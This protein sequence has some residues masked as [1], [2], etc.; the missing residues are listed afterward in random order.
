MAPLRKLILASQSPRR[1]ELLEA[2]HIPFEV[3]PSDAEEYHPDGHE[4][5]VIVIENTV[6]KVNAVLN[7][8][9]GSLIIGA[10]TIVWL[11]NETLAKPVD[12]NQAQQF[13]HRLSGATHTVYT[14]IVVAD[15]DSRQ[16]ESCVC[17]TDV[18]FKQ[19][20]SSDMD[21]YLR[22]INPYDKAGG[23]AIQGFGALVVEKINGC[24][25]NVMGLPVSMLD[26]LMHRF[27]VSL[28]DYI[29]TEG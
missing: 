7:R 27:G 12:F 1:K 6:R 8:Y 3:C 9:A 5:S 28:F 21:I 13:L 20:S 10:D 18:T 11:D 14:G 19:L 25:F 29:S 24:Y 2:L 4:P 16:T 23:Y 17:A 26:S 22:S 15:S